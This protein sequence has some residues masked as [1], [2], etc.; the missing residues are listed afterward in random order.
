MLTCAFAKPRFPRQLE[1]VVEPFRRVGLV[2]ANHCTHL[3]A[4][5]ATHAVAEASGA[6]Q[7]CWFYQAAVRALDLTVQIVPERASQEQHEWAWVHGEAASP[8]SPAVRRG[9]K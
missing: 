1:L 6:Q 8:C 3:S 7:W 2:T 5:Q 4:K 9:Q